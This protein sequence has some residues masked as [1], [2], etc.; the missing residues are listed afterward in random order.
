MEE[1][2]SADRDVVELL[3]R[4]F[5]NLLAQLKALVTSVSPE[6]IYKRPQSLS[7]ST[8]GEYILKSAAVAEQTFGGLTANLWDDPFEWTLPEA[9]SDANRIVEYLAEVDQA[10]QRAFSCF[11]NDASLLKNVS[12]PSGESRLLANVLVDALVR[13]NT[14]YGQALATHK[15]FSDVSASG[16]II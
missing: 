4:E 9:L 6:L 1:S 2:L 16:F 5:Q 8:L 10:R 15:I 13:A 14:Y 3:D 11:A 12:V 7:V